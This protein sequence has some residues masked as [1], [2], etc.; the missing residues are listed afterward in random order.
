MLGQVFQI[1]LQR[2]A[3]R[4]NVSMGRGFHVGPGSVLWAPE[5]LVLGKDVYVGKNVTIEVDGMVGDG[6]LFANL[7]GVVGR[8]DHDKDDRGKSIRRSRW[9][10]DF[11]E[12]LSLPTTIGSDVWI[13][14]G[15]IVLSGVTIGDSS[16]IAA[17]TVVIGDIPS[18]SIAVGNPARVVGT[19][20]S[21][22]ELAIHW[23]ELEATGHRILVGKMKAAQ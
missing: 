5:S 8:T 13:G 1:L 15:A 2:L 19:R 4:K 21:E 20:F 9:V 23:N 17:G 11:P 12:I 6:V 14:Y 16:I 3:V 18:N 22:S 7:S 10:G